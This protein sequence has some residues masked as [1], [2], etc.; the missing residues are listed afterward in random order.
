MQTNA[1]ELRSES[2]KPFDILSIKSF[3]FSVIL[4]FNRFGNNEIKL[5]EL[6]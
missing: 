4:F 2:L 6:F 5:C 3:R 1:L